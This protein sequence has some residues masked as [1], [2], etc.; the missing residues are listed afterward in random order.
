MVDYKKIRKRIML[1]GL[2]GIVILTSFILINNQIQVYALS[3]NLDESTEE[4][5][6]I[7]NE[8]EDLF[9][10]NDLVSNGLRSIGVG[11]LSFFV[12]FAASANSLFD[13]SFGMLNFTK[14]GPV[15]DFLKEW[16]VVWVA[17]LCVSLGWLGITLV[18]NSDKKPKFVTNLCVGILVVSSMSWMIS[19]MDSLLTKEVRN[20]ILGETQE[21]V[22]YDMLGNN[23]HDLLY[24]DQ[25]AGLENLN[26][27]N[28]DGV[29]YADIKTP[30]TKETWK[31]L[32]VNEI[33]FPDDVKDESKV[34]MENY[35]T[36][37]YDKNGKTKTELSECY[38]GVAWTD[39]LNTYYYRYSFDWWSAILEML[40][41][42]IVLVFF[43]YKIV[44]T[45]YEIVF[46]ELLAYLYS[47]NVANGQKV[48]KILD[49]IKNSYI[50]IL[51]SI[52]SVKMNLLATEYVSGK[53]W[54]GFTKGIFLFFVALA[55]IDGP[56]IVQKITGEDV[57]L[58]DGMQKAMSVM[59]GTS[60]AARAG[61]VA[62]SA[63]KSV[64]SH[65]ASFG[66]NVAGAGKQSAAES[67]FGASSDAINGATGMGENN[68]NSNLNQD[69][70]STMNSEDQNNANNENSDANNNLNAN[71]ES[72]QNQNQNQ[73][74][75]E[76][77]NATDVASGSGNGTD[78][79]NENINADGT[80]KEMTDES[81]AS[82]NPDKAKED[83]L[84]GMNPIGNGGSGLDDTSKMDADLDSNNAERTFAGNSQGVLDKDFSFGSNDSRTNGAKERSSSQGINNSLSTGAT[85]S[86]VNGSTRNNKLDIP[87][88][89]GKGS[90][91]S[92]NKQ[93]FN[94]SK[95][96]EK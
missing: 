70:G 56:N 83:M 49:S 73:E 74:G 57:G 6:K 54:G 69:G 87:S 14:Y 85:G 63:G 39:L 18:F 31:S 91:N 26:K 59:Y 25:V 19:Q 2:I 17:L 9:E 55:V 42:A 89:N 90:V 67:A 41:F 12:K 60:M 10:Q 96:S 66:K 86:S 27:K 46:Q 94:D 82:S 77:T 84:N 4:L 23:V 71:E 43:S 81:I 76:N 29:K 20:E 80:G 65:A 11:V 1:I 38:D 50:V 88:E 28:A 61:K 36:D 48:I 40:A 15:N 58:S 64:A 62:F 47:P 21:N 30:L 75:M 72:N 92:F 22:V 68:S 33:V 35:K 95:G 52:V 93:V 13:K 8:N 51:L 7:Y 79:L 32:K 16:Q 53:N 45:C 78:A 34:I 5:I 44:R 37:L 3:D 24:I